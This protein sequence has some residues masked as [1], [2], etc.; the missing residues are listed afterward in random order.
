[1]FFL[2]HT[3]QKVRERFTEEEKEQLREAITHEVICPRGAEIDLDKIPEALSLKMADA[4]T[5]LVS[6][7][8]V[9]PWRRKK[10]GI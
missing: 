8:G 2:D 9:E 1:M 10:T 4:L 6:P 5:G 3:W 7:L